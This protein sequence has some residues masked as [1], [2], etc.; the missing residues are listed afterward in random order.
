MTA[1]RDDAP[2]RSA[3]DRA[4]GLALL[5]AEVLAED[6]AAATDRAWRAVLADP[7]VTP[8][9]LLPALLG[10]VLA[11]AAAAAPPID[12]RP[13]LGSFVRAGDQ[14]AGWW[15]REP[16]EWDAGFAPQRKHAVAALRRL[17]VASRAALVLRDAAGLPVAEVGRLLGHRGDAGLLVESARQE[18]LVAID[19]VV[20]DERG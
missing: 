15:D 10:Q 14:W 6:S 12:A 16:P 17:P 19:R 3:A 9:T 20:A 2:D 5:L 18:Y 7:A 1:A 13:P 4:H 8:S 11:G